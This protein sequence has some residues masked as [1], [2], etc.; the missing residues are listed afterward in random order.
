MKIRSITYFCNPRW[1]LEEK[2]LRAAGAFLAQAKSA[3]EAASYEVQTVRLATI[4]FDFGFFANSRVMTLE[5][6]AIQ[7]SVMRGDV[8]EL[9]S[10]GKMNPNP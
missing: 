2:I 4:N 5:A 8:I 9:G 3:Y 6:E 1:P 7:G 10:R